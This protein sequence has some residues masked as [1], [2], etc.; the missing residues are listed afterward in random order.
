MIILHKMT[1]SSMQ[2]H[3]I[4]HS[5]SVFCLSHCF[6][7]TVLLV[8]C[9]REALLIQESRRD[10]VEVCGLY[11]GLE[12]RVCSCLFLGPSLAESKCA[13]SMVAAEIKVFHWEFNVW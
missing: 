6:L 10:P 11:D 7:M 13:C 5:M 9:L 2:V 3:L 4:V 8:R 1:P 12:S